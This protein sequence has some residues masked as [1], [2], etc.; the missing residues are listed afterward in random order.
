MRFT[1][2]IEAECVFLCE[3]FM[4]IVEQFNGNR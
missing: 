4:L 2:E 1:K 3:L